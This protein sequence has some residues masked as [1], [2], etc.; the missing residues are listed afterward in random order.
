MQGSGRS[1]QPV[2]IPQLAGR[3]QR[4]QLCRRFRVTSSTSSVW[5]AARQAKRRMT[6]A[7]MGFQ[8]M[9]GPRGAETRTA[10]SRSG[11]RDFH[12]SHAPSS[13]SARARSS[14]VIC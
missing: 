8:R 10:R 3:H 4:V 12:I 14:R 5:L 1:A 11:K 9:T 6:V 13:C 7:G 2:P